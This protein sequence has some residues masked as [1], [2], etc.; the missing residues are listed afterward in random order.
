MRLVAL[1]SIILTRRIEQLVHLCTDFSFYSLNVSDILK[2]LIEQETSK[3]KKNV[4]ELLVIL[5]NFCLTLNKLS[6]QRDF[7]SYTAMVSILAR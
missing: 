4:K 2:I 1:W 5:G 6:I 3:H 7:F